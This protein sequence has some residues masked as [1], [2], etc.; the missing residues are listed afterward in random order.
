MEP[1]TGSPIL[2]SPDEAGGSGGGFQPQAPIGPGD[3]RRS[4]SMSLRGGPARAA[5]ESPALDPA[6]QS[7]AEAIGIA[8]LILQTAMLALFVLY[9]FSG[10]TYIREGERG[11]ALLFGRVQ[12]SNLDPG[13]RLSAPYPLGEIVRVSTGV[14]E[15]R[16]DDAFWVDVPAGTP[17]DTSIEKLSPTTSLK[18]AEKSGSLLTAD[19]SIAHARVSV[20]YRHDDAAN[21]AQY[22]L[23]EHE[24][25]L[26]RAAVQRAVVQAAAASTIDDFLKPGAGEGNSVADRAK[27]IAQDLLARVNSGIAIDALNIESP[28]APLFIRTEFAS[29]QTAKSRAAKAIEEAEGEAKK[30]LNAA[31]GEA[32]PYLVSAIDEY[33]S[34]DAG[35]KPAVLAKIDAMLE[36]RPV[37]VKGVD[38]EG[39]TAEVSIEKL[40]SGRASDVLTEANTFRSEIV[41]Q[42]KGELGL[43]EAKLEQFRSNPNL[44]ITSE[45][46]AAY[47]IFLDRPSVQ[48]MLLPPGASQIQLVLNSDPDIQKAIDKEIRRREGE[49]ATKRRTD[50]VLNQRFET[51]PTGITATP[52]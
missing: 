38:V 39:R 16:V 20:R 35:A 1:L 5:D 21:Y 42:R 25:R 13:F 40:T 22:I 10:A 11:I 12:A 3:E 50:Q 46:S 24:D 37:L 19:G 18:P 2:L 31:A 7:L 17:R 27:S 26:V 29:V 44:M 33:E 14:K 32:A 34:A 23:P 49:E 8:F 28:M 30:T 15:L 9:I 45:W 4:S 47:G 52:D 41:A 36:G 48:V 6:N 43:F 51:R